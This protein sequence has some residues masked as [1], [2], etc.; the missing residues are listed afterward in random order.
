MNARDVENERKFLVA[1]D[2]SPQTEGTSIVQGYFLASDGFS[3]RVRL[4]MTLEVYQLTVKGPRSG[5]SRAEEETALSR[6][7]AEAL[8]QACGPRI[9]EK[10]RYPILG[11]DGRRLGR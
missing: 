6:T 2:F 9:V 1:D 5:I 8:L 10:T 4:Y 7:M 11:P 3:V